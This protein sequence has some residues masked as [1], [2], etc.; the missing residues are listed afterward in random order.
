MD[1]SGK[2]FCEYH[3][4]PKK[5]NSIASY[6]Y[7]FFFVSGS[8]QVKLFLIFINSNKYNMNYKITK[9]VTVIFPNAS[10]Y[11]FYNQRTCQRI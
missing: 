5:V 7:M 8:K 6:F 9:D 2:S 10:T 1:N 4:K 11:D 3:R